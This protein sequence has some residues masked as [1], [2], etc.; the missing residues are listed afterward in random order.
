M[1][2]QERRLARRLKINLPVAYVKAGGEKYFGETLTKDISSTGLRMNLNAFFPANTSFLLKLHFPEFDKIVETVARIVWCQR[3]SFSDQYQVG[4][5]FHEINT[6]FKKW[7][8]EYILSK[9]SEPP[10]NPQS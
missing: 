1:D 7:V 4:L 8:E 10:H 9:E 6:F 2:I 3:I 5:K